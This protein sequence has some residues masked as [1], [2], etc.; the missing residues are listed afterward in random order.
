MGIKHLIIYAHPNPQSF[1]NAILQAVVGASEARGDEVVVRDLYALGFQPSLGVADF[2]EMKAGKVQ[3][4]VG[5]EQRLVT[6]AEQ[7]TFIYPLWWTGF[8]AILKGYIDRVFIYGFAYQY[9]ASGIEGLLK[10]KQVLLLT[11][12]G[13]PAPVYEGN[14]MFEAIR[15]TQD[16]G[17]FAFC[18]MDVK[19]HH[20]FAGVPMV[21]DAVRKGY[22][23]EA[24][25]ALG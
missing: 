15:K 12:Q 17:V 23:E 16:K 11:T 7:L 20:F 8:P 5:E 25:A 13:T 14:G 19:A 22:L 24:K 9:G 18:G 4:D 2:V 10:Q 6:W 21:D 3:A 1:N